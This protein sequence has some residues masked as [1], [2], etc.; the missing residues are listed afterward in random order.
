MGLTFPFPF[1]DNLT[2]PNDAASDEPRVSLTIINGIPVVALFTGDSGEQNSGF[3]SSAV[4]G[5]G[6]TRALSSIL[7]SPSF[8]AYPD[9]TGITQL[10]CVSESANGTVAP[11]IAT[12]LGGD[13]ISLQ[14]GYV[15]E[16]V[17]LTANSSGFT[18][19]SVTDMTFTNAPVFVD[20]WYEIRLHTMCLVSG[21]AGEWALEAR[22]N[23]TQIGRF[24][25]VDL[26][27]GGRGLVDGTVLWQATATASTDDF[28]VFANEVSGTSTL[29]LEASGTVPRTLTIKDVG[30]G[31]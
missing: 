18:S 21:A 14:R 13:V 29:T 28:D 25:F 12:L 2:I 23:G 4:Q 16:P 26:A 8:D 19:D 1:I 27:A 30:R 5:A 11:D 17:F 6:V 31:T 20:R 22:V 10:L 24:G 7:Q 3:V 15:L 9:I